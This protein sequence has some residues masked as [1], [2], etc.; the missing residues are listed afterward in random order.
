M[1]VAA[2]ALSASTALAS[3]IT[4]QVSRTILNGSV[5]GSITTD[6]TIGSLTNSNIVTWSLTLNDGTSPFTLL[7]PTSGNN[8]QV[9]ISG[10][11]FTATASGLFFNYSDNTG[12]WVL[13]QNPSL[14]SSVNFWC[15]D[16]NSG[17]CEGSPNRDTVTTSGPYGVTF[18]PRTGTQQV[19][20][21]GLAAVPEP[22]SLVLLGIG[23]VGVA[24][25]RI[26]RKR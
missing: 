4:Y 2:L 17:G 6:G 21:T 18:A 9:G 19:A 13:F 16:S 25:M 10:S 11:A 23:L 3:P 26:V 8:S 7:G 12:S 24:R 15:M 5:V 20:G 1:L 22:A 14:G